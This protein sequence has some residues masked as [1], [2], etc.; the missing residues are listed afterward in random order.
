MR[1]LYY[2]DRNIPTL[3]PMLPVLP[4]IPNLGPIHSGAAYR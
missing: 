2:F 1:G 3:L 4:N